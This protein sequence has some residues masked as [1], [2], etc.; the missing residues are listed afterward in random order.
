[1]REEESTSK[2]YTTS[3]QPESDNVESPPAIKD[4]DLWSVLEFFE[5]SDVQLAVDV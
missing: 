4:T 5:Q 2:A 3:R 1:M